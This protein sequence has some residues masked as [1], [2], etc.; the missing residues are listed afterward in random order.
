[1]KKLAELQIG[2]MIIKN[3]MYDEF[4]SPTLFMAYKENKNQR[5]FTI[6]EYQCRCFN[7]GAGFTVKPGRTWSYGERIT[8][9]ACGRVHTGNAV[10]Y[11]KTP[12]TLLPDVTVM[13]VIDFKDRVDCGLNITR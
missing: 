9:P 1:M 11:G 3:T 8:C 12:Y 2:N 6:G 10:M 5:A 4:G 13:K 7:C